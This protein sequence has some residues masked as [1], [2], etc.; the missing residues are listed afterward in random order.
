[1]LV[2]DRWD[3][4]GDID[5]RE[6]LG[7]GGPSLLLGWVADVPGA[8]SSEVSSPPTLAMAGEPSLGSL[9][10]VSGPSDSVRFVVVG[11]KDSRLEAALEDKE[12]ARAGVLGALPAA[13]AERDVLEAADGAGGGAID[14]LLMLGL[15]L[16]AA[17]VRVEEELDV[18]RLGRALDAEASCFVGDFVGDYNLH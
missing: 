5:V 14:R 15:S 9:V 6:V 13:T 1:M 8:G 11:F 2:A 17:G 3:A 16:G 18:V 12:G 7:L 4:P 10:A